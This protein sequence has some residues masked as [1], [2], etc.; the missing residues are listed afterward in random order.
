MGWS[1]VC[2]LQRSN[3][4]SEYLLRKWMDQTLLT[5][6]LLF[7]LHPYLYHFI[8]LDEPS[9]GVYWLNYSIFRTLLVMIKMFHNLFFLIQLLCFLFFFNEYTFLFEI[10]NTQKDVHTYCRKTKFNF[11]RSIGKFFYFLE[12]DSVWSFSSV[13]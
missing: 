9:N 11:W 10:N 5:F 3:W 6:I 12:M 13:L 7:P 4:L 8:G 1:G 2:I